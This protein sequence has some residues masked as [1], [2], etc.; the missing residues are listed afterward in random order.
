MTIIPSIGIIEE[1]RDVEAFSKDKDI[2]R[3][4]SING[5]PL[6]QYI[7]RICNPEPREVIVQT[8][9]QEVITAKAP[10]VPSFEV[11]EE[12]IPVEFQP[13]EAEILFK[14]EVEKFVPIPACQNV[15]SAGIHVVQ[16]Q[17]TLFGIA[18]K[19]QLNIEDI[20]QWL[21]LIHI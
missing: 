5:F 14:K 17:E 9:I 7:D 11:I 6:A 3:L 19:Y 15:S 20:R 12:V 18:R 21:S 10:P 2:L 13:A 8:P 4:E 16:A 1:R